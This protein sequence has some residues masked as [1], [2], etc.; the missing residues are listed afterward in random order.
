VKSAVGAQAVALGAAAGV[1]LFLVASR[2]ILDY[3]HITMAYA[4]NLAGHW[5]W[6]LTQFRGSNTATSPLNVW[7]LAVGIF[8]TVP[9]SWPWARR[10]SPPPS[11]WPCS[12]R[13]RCSPAL[14]A[15]KRF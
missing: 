12:S 4:G 13:R 14:S 11:L 2:S 7:L 5:H 15:W 9:A 8:V 10:S 3:G 6:G 1:L